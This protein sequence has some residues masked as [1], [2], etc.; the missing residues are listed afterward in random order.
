MPW[1]LIF[2]NNLFRPFWG[3]YFVHIDETSFIKLAMISP[4]YYLLYTSVLSQFCFRRSIL[5]DS[6]NSG[7]EWHKHDKVLEAVSKIE[8]VPRDIQGEK[9]SK[10][11]ESSSHQS[12]QLEHK[13]VSKRGT[14][15]GVRKGRRSLLACHTRCKCSL[16]TTH[17]SVKLGIKVVK[18]V[19]ILSVG[20]S[21]LVADQNVI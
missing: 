20:K 10:A 9:L 14:E 11:T 7:S 13:Q 2:P 8:K 3:L 1:T 4:N 19:K 17:N 5:N 15:P 12:Q 21:L 16:Q 18:L 6:L